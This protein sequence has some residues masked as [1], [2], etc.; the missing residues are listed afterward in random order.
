VRRPRLTS[1][2]FVAVREFLVFLIYRNVLQDVAYSNRIVLNQSPTAIES[3][4]AL[5]NGILEPF[6]I[7]GVDAQLA[8]QRNLSAIIFRGAQLGLLLFSQPSVWVFGWK[9]PVTTESGTRRTIV[10]FPSLAEVKERNGKQR[11]REIAAP[12][13]VHL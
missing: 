2:S 9:E 6:I 7:P 5:I 4:V 1:R 13:V 12:A 3:N 8:Q 11:L 10:V